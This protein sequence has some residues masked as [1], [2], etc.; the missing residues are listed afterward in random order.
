VAAAEYERFGGLAAI[1]AAVAGLLYAIFFVIVD[2]ELTSGL[3]LLLSGLLAIVA[4][5][6]AYWR[7]REVEPGFALL[8]LLLATVGGAG[9]AIHGAFDLAHQIE[10]EAPVPAIPNFVDPRGLLTF[11]VTGLAILLI[12]W[13]GRRGGVLPARLGLLGYAAA[14]VLISL[15]LARLIVVDS[16]NPLVAIPALLAG[17]LLAPAWYVWLG[18]ELRRGRPREPARVPA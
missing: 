4:L 9:A 7:V 11:G 14:A 5:S 12:A 1:G 16:D 18:L 3:F 10:S 15:Y 8:A 6:A 17:F 13:L 2:D